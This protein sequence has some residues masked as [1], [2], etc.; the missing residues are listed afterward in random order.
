M[1]IK[2]YNSYIDLESVLAIT[3]EEESISFE[4]FT[5]QKL[6]KTFN[7]KKGLIDVSDELFNLIKPHILYKNGDAITDIQHRLLRTKINNNSTTNIE[8]DGESYIVDRLELKNIED[9]INRETLKEFNNL[10]DDVIGK[11]EKLNGVS[12][13]LKSI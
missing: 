7:C 2:F 11:W 6:V 3:K 12:S 10:C 4:L 5:G 1:K 8:Y 9:T 13:Y